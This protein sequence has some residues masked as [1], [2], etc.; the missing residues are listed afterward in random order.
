M[1]KYYEDDTSN[2]I[3]NQTKCKCSSD[4]NM[5]IKY[6]F[7]Q[8]LYNRFAQLNNYTNVTNENFLTMLGINVFLKV[9]NKL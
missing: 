1:K 8:K 9:M 5:E 4:T 7:Y 3:S 2:N 6:F